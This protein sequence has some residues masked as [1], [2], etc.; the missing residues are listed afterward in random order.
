MAGFNGRRDGRDCFCPPVLEGLEPRLLL[1][2]MAL[3]GATI[4][5]LVYMGS[6]D[7]WVRATLSNYVTGVGEVEVMRWAGGDVADMPVMPPLCSEPAVGADAFAVY[8]AEADEY[9]TLTFSTIPVECVG[10]PAMR[11]PV[12]N[13]VHVWDAS[14]TAFLGQYLGEDVFAPAG[15]GA[16][17]IGGV[18]GVAV[19]TTG[20]W[21]MSA[22]PL[23][24]YPG[25][26]LHAGFMSAG[27]MG[28]VVAYAGDP[29]L[30]P[31]RY[32]RRVD[33]D[34]LHRVIC[35]YIAGMTDRFCK[36]Q[37]AALR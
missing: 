12:M 29:G 10:D 34:G 28:E 11:V 26:E 37:H 17:L 25:G 22:S 18:A 20:I 6:Q 15:S 16:V 24:C 9:T 7:Q 2:T 21:T 14:P 3:N 31:E 33:A 13:E 32:R 19:T 27:P 36:A 35:D 5:N 23:G 4:T 8:I 30:L 1:T